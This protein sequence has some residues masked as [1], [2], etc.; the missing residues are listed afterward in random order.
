MKLA[1]GTPRTEQLRRQANSGALPVRYAKGRALVGRP[2]TAG[3]LCLRARVD[4]V[5]AAGSVRGDRT[6][7]AT[8]RRG[9]VHLSEDRHAAERTDSVQPE[10]QVSSHITGN[11]R[12]WCV[13][14]AR[15]TLVQRAEEDLGERD[16]RGDELQSAS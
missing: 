3:V 2:H 14:E 4:T 8:G 7:D 1:P 11:C 16:N 6:S 13:R 5:A 15:C 12:A 9:A 10:V